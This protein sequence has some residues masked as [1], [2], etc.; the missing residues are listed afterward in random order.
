MPRNFE[1]DI[2]NLRREAESLKISYVKTA[3]AIKTKS[4]Q[5][6]ITFTLDSMTAGWIDPDTWYVTA[7]TLTVGRAMAC[8]I[9]LDND[10]TTVQNHNLNNRT[11]TFT[12]LQ[13]GDYNKWRID[14]NSLNINDFNTISGGGKVEL[15]Y[16]FTITGTADFTIGVSHNA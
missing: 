3:S 5:V 16:Y 11:L 12:K 9:T 15:T 8:S 6:Q 4:E 10:G 7:E 1:Q 13:G 14:L 2:R